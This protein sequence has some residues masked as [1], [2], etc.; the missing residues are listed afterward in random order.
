MDPDYK[1]GHLDLSDSGVLDWF[2]QDDELIFVISASLWPGHVL[3]SN[4]LPGEWT[5]YKKSYFVFVGAKEITG[6]LNVREVRREIDPDP[7]RDPSSIDLGDIDLVST[8]QNS[9]SVSGKFGDVTLFAR[10][11]ELRLAS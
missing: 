3:Y 2:V 7:T 4:P 9:Y 11:I 5:C 8:G 6:L 1:S 10:A